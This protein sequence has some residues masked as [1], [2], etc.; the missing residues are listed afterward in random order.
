MM[1][2]STYKKG[3]SDTWSVCNITFLNFT[4][5]HN[6]FT[7]FKNQ[8]ECPLYLAITQ[9]NLSYYIYNTSS[10]FYMVLTNYIL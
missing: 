3:Y 4:V 5:I 1:G 6:L 10:I 2:A 8:I 7:S 9:T